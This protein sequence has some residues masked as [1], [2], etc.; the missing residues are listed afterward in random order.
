MQVLQASM[1]RGIRQRWDRLELTVEEIP[2]LQPIEYFMIRSARQWLIEGEL[3]PGAA[4]SRH[5]LGAGAEGCRI[6][7]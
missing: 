7:S 6:A 5:D 2:Y 4:T 1:I 3:S